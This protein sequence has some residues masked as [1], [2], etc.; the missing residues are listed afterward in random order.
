MSIHTS[1]AGR[2]A[3]LSSHV[4]GGE[5]RSEFPM[6]L[7]R[8]R[9]QYDG[10]FF[11][12]SQLSRALDPTSQ[13]RDAMRR[14]SPHIRAPHVLSPQGNY[15]TLK[16]NGDAWFILASILGCED[17][18]VHGLSVP[19]ITS[20]CDIEDAKWFVLNCKG[21]DESAKAAHASKALHPQT[22]VCVSASELNS[23]FDA[24]YLVYQ[25]EDTEETVFVSPRLMDVYPTLSSFEIN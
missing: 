9:Q 7:P 15:H 23:T 14:P 25:G 3:M 11:R 24:D 12:N 5:S 17:V 6:L 19:G 21:L 18:V 13:V 10:Q 8:E 16:T 20:N 4:A 2:L 1:S 22:Y